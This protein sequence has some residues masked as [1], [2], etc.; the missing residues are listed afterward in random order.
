[1]IATCGHFRRV[2]SL[3]QIDFSTFK[4]KYENTNKKVIKRLKDVSTSTNE[5]IL[6]T[7]DDREGEIIAWHICQVCK[8]PLTTKRIVFREITKNEILKAIGQPGTINMNRVYAQMTRQILDIYIGFKIS[9]LLWKY[10]NHTLSA[11]RCQTPA[12]HLIA[13]REK[14]IESQ[15]Y[16]TNYKVSGFFTNKEIEFQLERHLEEEEVK[17][18]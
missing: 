7:D 2:N 8:L 17:P 1:V 15:G 5:I 18:F 13:E 9:P 3:E 16:E 6:A 12:L 14:E 11:G 4:I 10:V